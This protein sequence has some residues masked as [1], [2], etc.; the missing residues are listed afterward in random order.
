MKLNLKSGRSVDYPRS[1]KDITLRQY[2]TW[3]NDIRPAI[4]SEIMQYNELIKQKDEVEQ[5]LQKYYRQ[6]GCKTPDEL[7]QF[8]ETGPAKNNARRFLPGL[9]AR[10]YETVEGLERLFFINEPLWIAK[11][12][13]PY[14]LRVVRAL[15]GIQDD[16]TVDELQFLFEK[17]TQALA[18]P[19]K[20]EYKQI[21][22][23]EGVTYTLPDKLMSKSTLIEFAEAAQYDAALKQTQNGDAEGLLKMCAVL[24][25][26]SGVEEYSEAVF[27]HN[28][29]AFQ[30]LPL[31]TAYEISFFLIWLS[32]KYVLNSNQS[33]LEG[34]VRQMQN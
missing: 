22:L 3:H 32:S 31:Q 17:C 14:Q 26:P 19:E 18:A 34:M 29:E 9:L 8:L 30:T 25:R 4:P 7:K 24:M 27:N 20:L 11:N 5:E 1:A 33:I 28:V 21:Y 15:T 6:S 2:I 12:W 16:L 23:H 13:H 10:W